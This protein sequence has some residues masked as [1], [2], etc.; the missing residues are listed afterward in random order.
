MFPGN[1]FNDGVEAAAR[2]FDE[3]EAK[4]RNMASGR[5]S[6]SDPTEAINHYGHEAHRAWCCAYN[7]R[8]LKR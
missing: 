4:A 6:C 8:K 1:T 2:L 5:L 7:I 3:E